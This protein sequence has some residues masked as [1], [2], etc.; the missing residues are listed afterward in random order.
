MPKSYGTGECKPHWLTDPSDLG[1]HPVAAGAKAGVTDVRMLPP[2]RNWRLGVGLREKA[3][4]KFAG[5]PGFLG[6][7]KLAPRC[8]LH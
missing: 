3:E 7:S 1:V 2:G 6:E 5:F 4:V 8:V